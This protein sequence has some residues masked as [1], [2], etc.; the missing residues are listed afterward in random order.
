MYPDTLINIGSKGFVTLYGIFIA[1][2]VLLGFILFWWLAKK[3]NVEQK[4][5][6]FTTIN[7]I[8]STAFGFF[9][10][11]FFPAMGEL[12]KNKKFEFG[13]LSFVAGAVAGA[14]M[15]FSIGI[16]FRKKYKGNLLDVISIAACSLI[17]AH[18][19]GRIGCFF[20]GCCHGVAVEPG[21]VWGVI[22]KNHGGEPVLPTQLFEVAFDFVLCAFM[23]ILYLRE[24]FEHNLS[25]YM[26][27]YGSFRFL[28]EHLRHE[29][30]RMFIAK[31]F[32][33][34]M[35]VCIFLVIGGFVLYFVMDPFVKKRKA[36]LALH[37][38]ENPP[39][40]ESKLWKAIKQKLNI[41]TK[42][43][44]SVAEPI[45]MVK[46]TETCEI[47]ASDTTNSETCAEVD[48]SDKTPATDIAKTGEE[49]DKGD[50][51]K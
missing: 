7:L 32:S 49:V 42:K 16:A 9:C 1:I 29:P 47:N 37:P 10:S 51:T 5:V 34:T 27:G 15:F 24:K 14:I 23:V 6:D 26:I 19:I 2:G 38:V 30:T 48:N 22:F 35:L 50:R 36:Y 8:I 25:L 17:L 39:V 31:G 21:N 4:F 33:I 46:S 44:S 13:T 3:G 18:G 40:E 28:I 11:A 20:A 45:D 41:P 12:V 43:D